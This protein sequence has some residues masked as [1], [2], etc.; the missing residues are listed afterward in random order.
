M[1][2]K[3]AIVVILLSLAARAAF[4]SDAAASLYNQGNAF[5]NSKQFV[6]AINLYEQAAKAGLVN[7]NLYY[8]LGNAY[9]R[10]G[11]AG[12][13]MLNWSRAERLAPSDPDLRFNLGLARGQIARSLV[14]QPSSRISPASSANSKGTKRPG[15]ETAGGLTSGTSQTASTIS[16]RHSSAGAL[17]CFSQ[18][19][20]SDR[21]LHFIYN[22]LF[23]KDRDFAAFEID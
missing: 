3:R 7:S 18:R 2:I 19:N 21:V 10:G 13:A 16:Q 5:Y 12:R 15:G 11:D 8:N 22:F 4:G 23:C 14:A 1:I 20:L 17:A 9:W 6:N